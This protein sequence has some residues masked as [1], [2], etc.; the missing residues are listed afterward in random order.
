[1]I[2]PLNDRIAVRE[3]PI[4]PYGRIVLPDIIENDMHWGQVVA[5]GPGKRG[6]DGGRIP[7]NVKIGEMVAFGNLKS[8]NDYYEKDGIVLIQEGD[9]IG[10]VDNA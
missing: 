10:V 3:L 4:A 5:I 1:M 9:I 2:R 8:Y 6:K 7:L